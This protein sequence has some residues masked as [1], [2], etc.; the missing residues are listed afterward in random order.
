LAKKLAFNVQNTASF[1]EIWIIKL[2][3][4]KNCRKLAKFAENCDHNID[5]W[6]RRFADDNRLTTALMMALK[7][8]KPFRIRTPKRIASTRKQIKFYKKR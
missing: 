8:P 3:L 4:K 6:P 1:S 2:V 7:S 5:L